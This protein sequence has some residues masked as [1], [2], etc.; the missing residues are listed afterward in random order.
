MSELLSKISGGFY[1]QALGDAWAMP[2]FL[3]PQQTWDYYGGYIETFLD[4]PKAHPVHH[5]LLAGQ[6][7]DDTEQAAAIAEVIIQEGR[8]SAEGVAQALVNWYQRIGGDHSPYVGPSSRRAIQAIL[9]GDDLREVGKFGDT[10]GAAMRISPIGLINPGN[11]DQAIEDAVTSCVPSHYTDIA[12]SGAAAVA[13]AIAAALDADS[14]LDEI[15]QTGVKSA[16]EGRQYGNVWLGASI[17][18]R[19][20]WAVDLVSSDKPVR[21]RLQDVYDLIG[22]SLAMSE[23]VPAAFG[24]LAIAEGDP[25]QAAILA[26]AL[27]GDADTVAAMAC[28]IAGAWKGIKAFNPDH[29]AILEKA[30]PWLDFKGIING[31]YEIALKRK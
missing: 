20:E 12:I 7:T 10:N 22:T 19:I 4:G 16:E 29:L 11:V 26:A 1:G 25:T 6:V 30:N 23:A 31:L 5:D 8:V 2:A 24:I 28:A 21:E 13:G 15:I 27:S 9:R 3:N 18:R 14:T 17:P